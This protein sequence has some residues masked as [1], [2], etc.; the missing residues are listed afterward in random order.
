MPLL[1][2]ILQNRSEDKP[3]NLA[4]LDLGRNRGVLRAKGRPLEQELLG[5]SNFLNE[6]YLN[7]PNEYM[8]RIQNDLGRRRAL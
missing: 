6:S 4:N 8:Q 7:A 1:T 5:L 2:H 3:L